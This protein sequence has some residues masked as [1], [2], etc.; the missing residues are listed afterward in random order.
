MLNTSSMPEGLAMRPA[1]PSDEPFLQGL[2]QSARPDLQWIDGEQELIDSVVAGQYR[3]QQQGAGANYPNALHFVI[4]KT[5]DAIGAMIADFG[6]NEVRLIYLAFVPLARGRGYG[7][8]VLQGVQQ[9]AQRVFSPVAVVV[10]RNN[11]QARRLYLEMG[12]R[13]EESHPMAER[14]AWYP[15]ADRP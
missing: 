6:H 12:F 5:G 13:V 10:W 8:A 7:K 3:V 14:L 2:Y 9:A 1:R 15:G 11:P 4:E